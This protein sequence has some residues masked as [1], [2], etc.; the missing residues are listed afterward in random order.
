MIAPFVT[1]SALCGPSVESTLGARGCV[2]HREICPDWPNCLPIFSGE[3]QPYGVGTGLRARAHIELAQDRG[4]VMRD[5]LGARQG[6]LVRAPIPPHS[7][8]ERYPS[9]LICRA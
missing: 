2:A 4:D 7:S 9:P 3:S 1:E 8:P 5:R 6:G